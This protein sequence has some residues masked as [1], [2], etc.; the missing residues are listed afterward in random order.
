MTSH[1]EALGRSLGMTLSRLDVV[2]FWREVF[3]N[4]EDS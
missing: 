1:L 2:W 4:Y 3:G